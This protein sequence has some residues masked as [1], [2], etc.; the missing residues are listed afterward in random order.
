MLLMLLFDNCLFP[1][2]SL[3]PAE[4]R[5]WSGVG[6]GLNLA[7]LLCVL[8]KHLWQQHFLIGEQGPDFGAGLMGVG[9]CGEE[10]YSPGHG[11]ESF[12]AFRLPA[13]P[14]S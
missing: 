5:L 12:C 10:I 8:R 4:E 3:K 13:F 7:A 11:K 6:F 14:K 9:A 1:A 2:D